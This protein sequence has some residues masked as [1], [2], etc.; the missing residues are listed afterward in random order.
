MALDKGT[1]GRRSKSIR[2]VRGE[3]AAEKARVAVTGRGRDVVDSIIGGEKARPAA[4]RLAKL[5][6]SATEK[7]DL[8]G[9]SRARSKQ[10]LAENNVQEQVAGQLVGPQ[11]AKLLPGGA[12]AKEAFDSPAWLALEAA[13]ILPFGRAAR[14][15]VKAA[16][17]AKK[18]AMPAAAAKV[19]DVL[20]EARKLRRAQEAG[21]SVERGKRAA[22]AS[23]AMDI[24]GEAGYR[25]ALAELK[26]ELPKLKLGDD[27][28]DFDQATSD[29]LFTHI[30]QADFK[31]FEKIR[32]Q[33]ALRKV[34][35]GQVP[36][37]SEIKLLERAFGPELGA[38]VADTVT[39]WRKAKN[40]GLSVINVP[41]SL[42]ASFDLS[43]PFR[44]G[45]VLGARHPKMFASEFKPM[46][47]AF[48]RE[49]AYDDV[50]GEI[51]E[52]ASYPLMQKAK[53][54]L[55]DLE[56]S[57]ASREDYFNSQLAETL[58]GGRKFSPVRMSGR[59]YTAFLN[60]FRADAFDN[61]LRMA[62]DSG[63]EIDDHLLKSL[64]TFINTA[65]GRG[66]F[67]KLEPSMNTLTAVFFSPRLIASR[68]QFFNPARY[69][70]RLPGVPASTH[71]FAAK[72]NRV[73]ARNLL[74]A[75]GLT[76]GIAKMAGAEVED[77]TRSADFGKIKI[78]NTRIDITGG[79]QGYV[80][81]AARQLRGETKSSTTGKV[82]KL[83]GGLMNRSRAAVEWD[84]AKNKLAPVAR[85]IVG[86][87]EDENFEGDP[88]DPTREAG[89]MFLPIGAQNA[90][91]GFE[92]GVG[93][94]I[95]S[96]ALNTFGFGVMTY[97]DDKPK[98][99]KSSGS[100]SIR[101][102]HRSRR[103]KS[104]RRR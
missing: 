28:R 26:G 51:G 44:Q 53:L 6:L 104:I 16:E 42:Q 98:G 22:K 9:Y 29:E 96:T 58:T 67:K 50:M 47:K 68:L 3:N 2:R 89:K 86:Q 97:G 100:K 82:K 52:R 45:L 80:V 66:S 83:E 33:T 93:T 12:P 30:Q 61:Y 101:R 31:P 43:A 69:G 60:K 36:T 95:A 77:D 87:Q 57:L 85:Y 54:A 18:A 56:G 102:S 38:Q 70:A 99:S 81:N 14:G 75:M 17:A 90:R 46:L 63:V 48:A 37:K 34:L 19:A 103:S 49:G 73:A 65:T 41:R 59:A 32:T 40:L 88:F 15:G 13:G 92:E 4:A 21:Y 79:H 91:E 1:G 23:D 5:G 62:E 94:G 72:Q 76:L 10:S 74:G 24:G 11:I 78:G 39:W 7:N 84:F 71:P 25:A 20:P 55:T 35:D 64:A 27:L 8:E